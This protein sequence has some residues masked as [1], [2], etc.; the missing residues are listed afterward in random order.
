MLSCA[1]SNYFYL[2]FGLLDWRVECE[3]RPGQVA[4]VQQARDEVEEQGES[5]KAK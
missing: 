4:R 5:E 3:L 1:E 2:V